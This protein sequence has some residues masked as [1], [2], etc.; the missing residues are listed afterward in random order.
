MAAES[1]KKRLYQLS[2]DGDVRQLRRELSFYEE[3]YGHSPDMDEAEMKE[4]V[5]SAHKNA[6]DKMDKADNAE[7]VAAVN[8]MEARDQVREAE[9]WA[10]E[11]GVVL[12]DIDSL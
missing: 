10:G 2:Y 6:W 5:S 3:L 7:Q 12:T 4:L 11:V 1:V 8:A 9:D